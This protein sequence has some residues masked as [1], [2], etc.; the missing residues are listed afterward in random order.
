MM[1]HL[2]FWLIQLFFLVDFKFISYQ[3]LRQM[4]IWLASYH[5][6]HCSFWE[7]NAAIVVLIHSV[8]CCCGFQVHWMFPLSCI[9]A[10]FFVFACAS[11]RF[12]LL[13]MTVP[14]QN[15]AFRSAT[16]V[17]FFF[18]FWAKCVI[19]RNTLWCRNYGTYMYKCLISRNT[20]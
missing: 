18:H 9:R 16:S 2:L 20:L 8:F 11:I 7:N 15:L 12:S 14:K 5:L 6:L 13:A 4:R 3:D 19:S 10:L 1:P 17:D